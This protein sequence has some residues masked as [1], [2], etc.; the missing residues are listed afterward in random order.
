M[1]GGR[2]P[3]EGCQPNVLERLGYPDMGV[4]NLRVRWRKS[5]ERREAF[6]GPVRV[7]V[8]AHAATQQERSLVHIFHF[9]F[10]G[11]SSL[12]SCTA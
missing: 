4:E 3:G 7:Q 1:P 8:V 11:G 10:N 5:N 2:V 6:L 9:N 12:P